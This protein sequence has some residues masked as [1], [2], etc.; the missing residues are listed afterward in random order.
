MRERERERERRREIFAIRP[1][2]CK[3]R[4]KFATLLTPAL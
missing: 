1:M 4:E 3:S 2:E